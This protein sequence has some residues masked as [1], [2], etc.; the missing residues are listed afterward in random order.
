MFRLLKLCVSLAAFCALAYFGMTVKLGSRT[1]FEHLRAIGQTKES[2][3]LVDG[4]KEAAEP[5]VDDVRRRIGNRH[6]DHAEKDDKA[7]KSAKADRD[8]EGGDKA[9]KQ[10]HAQATPDAGAAPRDDFSPSERRRLRHLLGAVEH[11]A[12]RE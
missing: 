9:D 6:A 12:S 4:T 7:D 10:A 11:H 8:D 1:L 5:L 2:Q 3:E